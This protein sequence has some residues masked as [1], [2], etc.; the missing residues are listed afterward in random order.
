[1]YKRQVKRGTTVDEMRVLAAAPAFIIWKMATLRTEIHLDH[2]HMKTKPLVSQGPSLCEKLEAW[3]LGYLLV[4]SSCKRMRTYKIILF[5]Y[6]PP[7]VLFKDV[8][9]QGF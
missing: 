9:L 4:S 8:I 5:T 1:M 2:L 3:I 7:W 6:R